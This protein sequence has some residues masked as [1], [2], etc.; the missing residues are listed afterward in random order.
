MA[1][2]KSKKGPQGGRHHPRDEKTS[3]ESGRYTAPI[4]KNAQSSPVWMAVVLIGL[5]VLG[6]ITIVVNYIAHVLPA[7]PSTWYLVGGVLAMA[8]GFLGLTN[9]K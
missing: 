5:I 4:P 9:Y 7:S 8:V 6:M 1:N 2:N 3:V